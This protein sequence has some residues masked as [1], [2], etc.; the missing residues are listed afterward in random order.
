L[1]TLDRLVVFGYGN[2]SRGDDAL[3][4]E[5][6]RLLEEAAPH[7]TAGI[8]L[9]L[10]TDF[11]LQ[12]EHAL[13]LEGQ[14]I[15]LFI[16]ACVACPAPFRFTRLQPTKDF[17]YTSHALSPAAVLQVYEQFHDG[18]PPPAFLLELRGD[19]FELGQPLSGLARN[20]LT[21]AFRF[22]RHLCSRPDTVLWSALADS[23]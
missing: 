17:S 11:Q 3:G 20:N 12:I 8:A 22:A 16:D 18:P 2:P 13:D 19:Q 15:A 23:E 7:Y 1:K 6:L 14:D 21:A 4:P 10:I 5:L 9:E